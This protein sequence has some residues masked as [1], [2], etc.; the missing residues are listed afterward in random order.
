MLI[1][2]HDFGKHWRLP[3]AFISE[4]FQVGKDS[5][6][7]SAGISGRWMHIFHIIF[8]EVKIEESLQWK[9]AHICWDVFPN[10]LHFEHLPYDACFDDQKKQKPKRSLD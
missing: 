3:Q 9:F 7:E 1:L 6:G 8:H 2:W 10:I 5:N 4:I